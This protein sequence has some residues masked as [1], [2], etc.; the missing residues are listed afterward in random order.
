VTGTGLVELE[1][2]VVETPIGVFIVDEKLKILD[3]GLFA[4]APH[5]AAAELKQIQ[6]GTITSN[7]LVA[8]RNISTSGP[9]IFENEL[10]AKAAE[11]AMQDTGDSFCC[12]SEYPSNRSPIGNFL[13]PSRLGSGQL[14]YC[15]LDVNYCGCQPELYLY[16]P[17]AHEPGTPEAMQLLSPCEDSFSTYLSLQEKFFS[18][19]A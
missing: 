12:V 11:K 13:T 4:T 18:S 19:R 8:L 14:L 10:F 9:L 7:V 2:Y 15:P 17:S 16:L 1:A 3:K 5:L 6:E